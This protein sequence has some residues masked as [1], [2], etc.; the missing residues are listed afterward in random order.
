MRKPGLLPEKVFR[1]GGSILPECRP[2]L[3]DGRPQFSGQAVA[4]ACMTSLLKYS[5][6]L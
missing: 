6:S 5:A 1:E 4:D 2:L 3:M